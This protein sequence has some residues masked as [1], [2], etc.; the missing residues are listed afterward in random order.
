MRMG[1]QGALAAYTA[2]TL[3]I[4]MIADLDRGDLPKKR[5]PTF[6]GGLDSDSEGFVKS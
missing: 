3:E 6:I 2:R 5:P 1:T 4:T